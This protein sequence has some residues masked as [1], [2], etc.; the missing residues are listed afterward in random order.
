MFC[1]FSGNSGVSKA[2]QQDPIEKFSDNDFG[3]D[4]TGT[5]LGIIGKSYK[6]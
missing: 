1:S 5:T 4:V 3:Q 6:S 2:M